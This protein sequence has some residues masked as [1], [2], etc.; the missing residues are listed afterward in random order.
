MKNNK[1]TR[2]SL[3]LMA[4][5]FVMLLVVPAYAVENDTEVSVPLGTSV[6]VLLD[7]PEDGKSKHNPQEPDCQPEADN[8]TGH[9]APKADYGEEPECQPEVDCETGHD[10]P[11]DVFPESGWYSIERGR[12]AYLNHV[13][14]FVYNWE[15]VIFGE[16]IRVTYFCKCCGDIQEEVADCHIGGLY[17][18]GS[19]GV[20]DLEHEVDVFYSKP[21]LACEE[22]GYVTYL[23]ECCGEVQEEYVEALGHLW[24]S[25]LEFVEEHEC[26]DVGKVIRKCHYCGEHRH[27]SWFSYIWYRIDRALVFGF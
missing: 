22:S 2:I 14:D 19:G 20:V 26:E 3:L 15:D 16:T 6:S 25:S 1:F 7:I 17:S 9:D 21:D 12:R 18:M 10:A 8:E 23:C 4:A 11:K 13:L 27:E 24:S 5:M